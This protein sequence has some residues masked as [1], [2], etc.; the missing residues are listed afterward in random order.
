MEN[1]NLEYEKGFFDFIMVG[2]ILQ[3][4]RIQRMLLNI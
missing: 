3:K 2:N 4:L 1:M